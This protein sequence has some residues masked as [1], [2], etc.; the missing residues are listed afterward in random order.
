MKYIEIIE[1]M[2]CLLNK[3]NQ[4]NKI[5]CDYGTG[6]I[7]YRSE[8][9]MIEAI[10]NHEN[11]NASELANILGITSGAITQVTSKLVKKGLIEQFRMPNNKKEVYY[12][13]TNLGKIANAKHSKN[14]E[15]LYRNVSRY[16]DGIN[17]DNIKV[18]NTFIDKIVENLPHE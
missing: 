1:K 10:N 11:V 18:I 16:L 17:P 5:P 8:I 7:L 4:V 13:L 15:K 2:A 9:H 3:I 14:H 12:R 6:H